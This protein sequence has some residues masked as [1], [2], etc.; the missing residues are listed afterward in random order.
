MS[1]L[2][3]SLRAN[4][5]RTVL[6]GTEMFFNEG[7]G[8]FHKRNDGRGGAE[9]SCHPVAWERQ[10]LECGVEAFHL[11]NIVSNVAERAQAMGKVRL[12]KCRK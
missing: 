9:V 11:A 1:W 4:L 2:Q 7:V 12:L 10:G 6:C 5:V 8:D 3:S